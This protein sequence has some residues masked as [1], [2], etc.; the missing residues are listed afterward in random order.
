[1]LKKS[2][3]QTPNSLNLI[4]LLAA[5]KVLYGHYRVHFNVSIPPV[6]TKVIEYIPGVPVFFFLSGFLIWHSIEKSNNFAEFAKK[7]IVRV[8]PELWG[9]V[10]L[11]IITIIVLYGKNVPILDLTLFAICQSTIIQFWTPESLRGYGCGT[12]NGPLWTICVLIQFYIVAWFLFKILHKKGMKRWLLIQLLGAVITTAAFYSQNMIPTMGF[13]LF[14]QTLIP[15][16]WLF[17]AGSLTAEYADKSIPFIKKYWAVFLAI[18]AVFYICDIDIWCVQ[19]Y[20]LFRCITVALGL[21]GFAYRFPKANIGYDISY[22]IYIYHMIV[23]NVLIELGYLN[24]VYPMVFAIMCTLILSFL[25]TRFIA[26]KR[27]SR[28]K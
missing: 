14:S 21:V 16:F 20:G 5:I 8:F 7:R 26:G 3:I 11:E 2:I 12:P 27:I 17:T 15:Y 9:G 25:S 1:M 24:N 22:S 13:K 6:I 18:S 4:R 28:V 19:H 23:A 10:L